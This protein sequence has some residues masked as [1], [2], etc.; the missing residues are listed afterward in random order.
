MP[1]TTPSPDRAGAPP[2]IAEVAGGAVTP[3]VEEWRDVPGYEGLYAVSDSGQVKSLARTIEGKRS[4]RVEERLL[5]PMVAQGGH[6]QVELRS[7][8]LP[9]WVP[10][11]HQLVL[12]AFVGPY[13]EGME[14]RHLDGD[15]ANNRLDN[16]RYGTRSEN[17]YDRVRHGNHPNANKTHCPEGH[18]YDAE[19]TYVYPGNGRRGCRVCIKAH[20]K[21][22]Y[23]RRKGAEQ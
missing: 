9:R 21:D 6:L 23:L 7:G 16:L 8:G 10:K 3:D 18:P 11:I 14:V 2:T 13:P 15:P 1:S 4:R 17:M 19:N 20:A 5:K 22:Y 12:L